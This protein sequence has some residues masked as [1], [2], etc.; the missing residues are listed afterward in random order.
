MGCLGRKCELRFVCSTAASGKA[1][2]DQLEDQPSQKTARI[3]EIPNLVP[4][5]CVHFGVSVHEVYEIYQK[6]HA[7]EENQGKWGVDLFFSLSV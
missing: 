3:H 5:Q 1:R 4:K 7:K 6:R 2:E